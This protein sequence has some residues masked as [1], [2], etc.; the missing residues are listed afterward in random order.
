MSTSDTIGRSIEISLALQTRLKVLFN[1]SAIAIFYILQEGY[2]YITS[3]SSS[4]RE[5]GIV[6]C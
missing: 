5:T 1:A 4:R 3:L 6:V 2:L